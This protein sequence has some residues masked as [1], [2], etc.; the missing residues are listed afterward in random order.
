MVQTPY[1]GNQVCSLHA[2][3]TFDNVHAQQYFGKLTDEAVDVILAICLLKE[4]VHQK[5]VPSL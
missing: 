1:D 5:L 2:Q 3:T 4:K